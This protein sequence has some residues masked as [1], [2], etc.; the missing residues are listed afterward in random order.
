MTFRPST[1]MGMTTKTGIRSKGERAGGPP[2]VEG[3]SS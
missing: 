1:I 2:L 3:H